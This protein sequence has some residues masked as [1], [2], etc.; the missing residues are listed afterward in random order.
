MTSSRVSGG[1]I[2][3]D[4]YEDPNVQ[5]ERYKVNAVIL[6]KRLRA[7]GV[8]VSVFKQQLVDGQWRDMQVAD[9]VSRQMEDAILTRARELRIAHTK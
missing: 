4:W 2:I 6:D 1:V 5:G 8:N 3:S 7:D 9:S